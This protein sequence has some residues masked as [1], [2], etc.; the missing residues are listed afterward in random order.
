MQERFSGSSASS[1]PPERSVADPDN[2]APD[3][4]PARIRPNFG[5]NAGFFCNSYSFK[6]FK[7]FLL[8]DHTYSKRKEY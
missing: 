3:P 4:D 6:V 1:S 8:E 7:R 5:K 2:F